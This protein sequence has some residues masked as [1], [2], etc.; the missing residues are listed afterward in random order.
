MPEA[1]SLGLCVNQAAEALP[2][3]IPGQSQINIC[4]LQ[5]E[6]SAHKPVRLLTFSQERLDYL[7]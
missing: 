2:P 3:L 5:Y 1:A 7:T 4:L 6:A